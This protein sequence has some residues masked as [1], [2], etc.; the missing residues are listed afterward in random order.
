MHK[1][2]P[3]ETPQLT[4]AIPSLRTT[5]K[6]LS[7]SALSEIVE[8][9]LWVGRL[10]MES[11]AETQRVEESVRIVG[12]GLGCDWGH[13][14]V[15]HG[16]IIA[17][18]FGG[19]DFRTKVLSVHSGGV[20]MTALEALSHLC[21][22]V[23]EHR[24]G[25]AEVRAELERIE[26]TGRAYSELQTWLSGGIGCAAFCG[27]FE[28]DAA[29]LALTAAA[30][31]VAMAVRSACSRRRY[32]PLVTAGVTALV[33]GIIVGGLQALTSLSRTPAAAL[34][35]SVL[36]LVPGAAAMNALEDLIKG[37]VLVGL[38]RAAF[39]GLIVIFA[40]LGLLF[41]MQLTAVRL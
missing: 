23:E 30:S 11:G 6:P 34:A 32:N 18:Y 17:T 31:S 22:R 4:A 12:V 33:A 19:G 7:R 28:G 5:A 36:M 26:G 41:A 3:V 1:P 24:F 14:V 37:H 39:A 16:A 35:A 8:L 9:A 10:Q 15:T 29:A 40:A 38:A 2:E 20:N 25:V 13:I 27:L 21:H